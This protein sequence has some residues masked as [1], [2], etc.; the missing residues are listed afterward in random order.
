MRP[1][2][3]GVV[4]I[5]CLMLTA[6]GGQGSSNGSALESLTLPTL[7]NPSLGAFLAP[8]IKQ[9][10]LDQNHGLDLKFVQKPAGTYRTDF[11]SGNDKVGASGTVLAD[12]ALLNE[13]GV[14]TVYL[15][16]VFDFWG[17]V[18]VP[19]NSPI[20]QLSDLN[21]KTMAAALPTTNY[22]MF[23]YIAQ[24]DKLPTKAISVQNTNTPGL[25]AQ[26]SA[27]RVDAVEMWEPAF[28]TLTSGNNNFRSLDLAAEWSKLTGQSV[29]PY[30][31]VAAHKDWAMTHKKEIQQL[32]AI[33]QDAAAFLK[34]N[35]DKA[36]KII[37]DVTNIDAQALTRLFESPRLALSIYPATK[38][39]DALNTVF[40]SAV[41]SGYLGKMPSPEV[42]F[43][44][45]LK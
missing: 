22:A 45:G 10:K 7:D 1:R 37:G 19:K 4:A 43:D 36:A 29:I 13:K 35:P 8:I 12:V 28:T 16:N 39:M 42:V 15:F 25:A 38:E 34:A 2:I 3:A 17:T 33:Y 31:G 20:Q 40:Q 14:N 32:Y 27:G 41:K 23:K 21:G 44:A 11:A 24:A 30:L 9:Q 26:A 6:C 5:S 18:V